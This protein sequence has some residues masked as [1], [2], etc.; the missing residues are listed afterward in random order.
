MCATIP[1]GLRGLAL[2]LSDLC[3]PGIQYTINDSCIW[4]DLYVRCGVQ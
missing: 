2:S 1:Q 4:R 3:G